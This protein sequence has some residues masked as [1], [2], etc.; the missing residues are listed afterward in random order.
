MVELGTRHECEECGTKF[1]DLGNSEIRCPKCSWNPD[2]P[3][4]D[5]EAAAEGPGEKK[6]TKKKATKKTAKKTAKKATKKK[7]RKAAKKE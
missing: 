7:A 3:K 1:Y 4:V 2:E 5:L 6:A